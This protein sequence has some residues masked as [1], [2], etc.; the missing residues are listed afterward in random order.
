[1]RTDMLTARRS[2]ATR[3]LSARA[4]TQVH[5]ERVH[6]VLADQHMC[7]FARLSIVDTHRMGRYSCWSVR[8]AGY[9]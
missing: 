1:M 3:P 6:P 7:I 4:G 5:P 9:Q 2:R 8:R